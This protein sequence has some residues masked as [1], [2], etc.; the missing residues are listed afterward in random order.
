MF[1]LEKRKLEIAGKLVLAEPANQVAKDLLA[2]IFEQIGYQQENPGLRNS[3][4]AATYELRNG[5]PQG[6]MNTSMT[7]NACAGWLLALY[8]AVADETGARRV[9]NELKALLRK[10]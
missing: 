1:G 9:Q 10:G 4:L 8:V 6:E 5:I 2:D 3:F 7:I